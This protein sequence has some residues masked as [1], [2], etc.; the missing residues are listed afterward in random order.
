MKRIHKFILSASLFFVLVFQSFLQ[1]VSVRAADACSGVTGGIGVTLPHFVSGN[2]HVVTFNTTNWSKD[3]KYFIVIRET[4]NGLGQIESS[5]SSIEI[6]HNNSVSGSMIDAEVNGSTLTFTIK[7]PRSQQN[8]GAF[9]GIQDEHFV[10]VHRHTGVAVGTVANHYC[11]AGSYTTTPGLRGCKVT[12]SQSRPEANGGSCYLG[13]E[14]SCLEVSGTSEIVVKVSDLKYSNGDLYEG[15]GTFR[16]GAENGFNVAVNYDRTFSGGAA[17]APIDPDGPG[18][19]TFQLKA[20]G[21]DVPGCKRD[22]RVEDVCNGQCNTD[23]TSQDSTE[24][25]AIVSIFQICSQIS[26]TDLKAKCEECAGGED[27]R[28]G[29]WTAVGC[30]ERDPQNIVQRFIEIGLGVGGGICLLMTLAAGFMLTTSQGDPK[31]VNEAKDMITSAIVGLL[32]IIFSVF[33]LQFIGVTIFQI[34]G[35]GGP[36]SP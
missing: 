22:I 9:T 11:S 6:D 18:K 30:I 13:G 25:V 29:V 16:F 19:Y 35:F 3:F 7:N 10:E 27:G 20:L 24:D 36:P 28:A 14:N 31:Q 23:E 15:E 33:I 1:P 4:S 17:E 5:S 21:Y 12:V 2:K 8:S 32:F 34:P 26:N